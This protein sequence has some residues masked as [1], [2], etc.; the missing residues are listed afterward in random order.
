MLVASAWMR[1]DFSFVHF[2]LVNIWWLKYLLCC[3]FCTSLPNVMDYLWFI[4]DFLFMWVGFLFV[5]M[6]CLLTLN[7]YFWLISKKPLWFFARNNFKSFHSLCIKRFFSKKRK[8]FTTNVPLWPKIVK[9]AFIISKC[10]VLSRQLLYSNQ[11]ISI[12]SLHDQC[13]A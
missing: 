3:F 7:T 9:W 11:K 10:H 5:F 2:I 1:S 12:K 6:I 13:S 4:Y 8:S